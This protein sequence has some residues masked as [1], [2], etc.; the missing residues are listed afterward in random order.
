VLHGAPPPS[1]WLGKPHAMY[2][3]SQ[4]ATGDWL[5]A[6]D[7]D[8]IFHPNVISA[9]MNYTLKN[10]LDVLALMPGGE[11]IS[12]W[13]RVILPVFVYFL[14]SMYPPHLANKP[15]SK[16]ALASGGFILMKRDAHQKI[17]GYERIKDHVIDDFYTAVYLKEAGYR[18]RLLGSRDTVYTRSYYGLNDIW[19]GFSKNTFAGLKHNYI[20]AFL[21]IVFLIA[22]ALI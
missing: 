20:F 11:F 14:V 16:H 10:Q 13:E 8:I 3:A 6:T 22:A 5:L 17:G 18:F 21:A 12:F 2:Q 15:K 19:E 9:A 7:A 1:G 4:A